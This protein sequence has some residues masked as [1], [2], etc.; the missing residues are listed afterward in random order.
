[1]SPILIVSEADNGGFLFSDPLADKHSAVSSFSELQT[2]V[3]GILAQYDPSA[4]AST[5]ST[6][7]TSTTATGA[8]SD[9]SSAQV[10]AAST[11]D[12]A[13]PAASTDTSTA[14]AAQ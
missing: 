13:T 11:A 5:A 12:Q 4:T 2:G 1:M 9:A 3:A 8:T 10:D 14:Q 7:S 6:D